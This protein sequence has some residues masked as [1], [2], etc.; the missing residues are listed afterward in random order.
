MA[1]IDLF[2]PQ[3]HWVSLSSCLILEPKSTHVPWMTLMSCT[4]SHCQWPVESIPTARVLMGLL[5]AAPQ[6]NCTYG[7]VPSLVGW[8]PLMEPLVTMCLH[9]LH[10]NP[11]PYASMESELGGSEWCT[12]ATYAVWSRTSGQWQHNSACMS[13][14]I[15]HIH[16]VHTG[17]T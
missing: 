8:I 9:L 11:I 16:C 4:T 13:E 5:V 3:D 12:L 15:L 2:L 17:N 7:W 14:L 10:L 1:K 6:G